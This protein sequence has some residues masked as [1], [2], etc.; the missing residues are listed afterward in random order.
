M[1]PIVTT[2]D[3]VPGSNMDTQL[4]H[5]LAY[6]FCIS[7]VFMFELVQTGGDTCLGFFVSQALHPLPERKVSIQF[8]VVNDLEHEASVA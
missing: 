2:V 4:Q 3:A 5:A 1:L 7:H 6:S 8:L